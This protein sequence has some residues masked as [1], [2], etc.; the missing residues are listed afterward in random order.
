MDK[1]IFLK[2]KKGDF[3][4][5]PK[6]IA[7]GEQT[8]TFSL[9]Y[10]K[11]RRYVRGWSFVWHSLN[12]NFYISTFKYFLIDT[13]TLRL[14]GEFLCVYKWIWGFV[15]FFGGGVLFYLASL[16]IVHFFVIGLSH[17]NLYF[18][19]IGCCSCSMENGELRCPSTEP[20]ADITTS[21]S[22]T[23]S[24]EKSKCL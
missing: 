23:P 21:G 16:Y 7:A 2:K 20:V 10:T 4:G 8:K 19:Y 1:N 12:V 17:H 14:Y 24:F 22:V 9:S 5:V 6:K 11:R 3:P 13:H 15:G 18:I